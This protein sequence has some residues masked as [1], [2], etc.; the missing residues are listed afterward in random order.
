MSEA[1]DHPAIARDG[2]AIRGALVQ[3]ASAQ[4]RNMATLAGPLLQRTRCL[5]FRDRGW[6]T[7][8]KRP[9]VTACAFVA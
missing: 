2:P 5:D 3:A 6:Q 8:N 4:R 9:D 1:A 7:C